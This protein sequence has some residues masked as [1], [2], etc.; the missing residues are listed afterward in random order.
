MPT[1]FVADTKAKNKRTPLEDRMWEQL[2]EAGFTG[3]RRNVRFIPGRR[4]EA[5]FYDPELKLCIECD[6][7]LWVPKSGHNGAGGVRDRERD[8]LA[9]LAGI[10]TYR[11]ATEHINSGFAIEA[12]KTL[13]PRRRKE[14]G[15]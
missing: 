10:V 6:G 13:I 11:F 12:L 1:K 2:L 5:D 14:L 15:L 3:F 9:A 4:F 8:I 7:G